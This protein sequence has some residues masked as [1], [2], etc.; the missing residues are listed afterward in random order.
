M[1][2]KLFGTDG[3]RGVANI[4]PITPETAIK[5][6]KAV[7]HALRNGKKRPVILIGK[8]TRLSGYMIEYALTSGICSMGAD[9]LLVGPMPTPAVAHLTKSFAADAGVMISASHNPY[10]HNGI[11][12]F[13]KDGFKLS[14]EIEREIERLVFSKDIDNDHIKGEKI[15]KAFRI[16]DAKGRYIEFAKSSIRNNSLSGLKVVLDCANG[17]AYDIAPH[18]FRELGAEVIILNNHP[19]GLNIN[20]ECGAMHPEV[21]RKKVIEEKADIGIALDGDADRVIMVD[22]KGDVLDG[23]H[24]MAVC[25]LEMKKESLLKNDSVVVTVLSNLGFERALEE[26]GIK[27]IRTAVGD[28]PVAEEMRKGG[29]NFGGEQCG[30]IIFL[31]FSTAGD[32]TI[33]ALQLMNIVKNSGKKLSSLKSCMKSYPQIIKNL[34]VKEK[35]PIGS[36]KNVVDAIR[37]AEE[38]L[39]NDGRLLVRYSGTENKARIMVEGRDEKQIK[40]IAESISK[41]IRKVLP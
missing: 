29:Y 38:I 28:K 20:K 40:E 31:D 3:I 32:G 19:D 6:G 30:H 35:K 5:V 22:E 15:G 18:I 24:I 23:D 2:K 14:D 7:A 37:K 8:D 26:K 39:G 33:T 34:E 13:D 11:K 10:E 36:M 41:E 17:A 25:A 9:V 4:E 27:V 21:I 16:G 1:D 12:I